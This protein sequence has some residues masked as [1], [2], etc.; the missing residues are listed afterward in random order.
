[1][2]KLLSFVFSGTP[3]TGVYIIQVVFTTSWV[4]LTESRTKYQC[5]YSTSINLSS[6]Q[7]TSGLQCISKVLLFLLLDVI[8]YLED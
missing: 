6:L 2:E 3:C 4:W 5:Q 8:N 7:R 1:M